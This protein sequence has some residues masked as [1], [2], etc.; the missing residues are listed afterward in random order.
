MYT[1]L[2]KKNNAKTRRFNYSTYLILQNAFDLNRHKSEFK[3]MLKRIH[4]EM[5]VAYKTRDFKLLLKY[6]ILELKVRLRT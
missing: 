1:L 5:T 3:A 4:F 2:L 6:I